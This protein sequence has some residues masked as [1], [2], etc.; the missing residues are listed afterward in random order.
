VL[1]VFGQWSWPPFAEELDQLTVVPELVTGGAGREPLPQRVSVLAVIADDRA[2]V[3]N[4]VGEGHEQHAVVLYLRQMGQVA[5]LALDPRR[6]RVL[7]DRVRAALDD[8]G[9]PLAEA[10]ADPVEH[11]PPAP[12]LDR[13]VKHRRNRL[14]LIAPLLEH[15]ARDDEQMREVGN[16]GALAELTAVNFERQLECRDETGGELW[17]GVSHRSDSPPYSLAS[18]SKAP[19]PRPAACPIPEA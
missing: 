2:G 13:V 10:I 12:V 14:V 4:L 17:R 1:Q 19:P 3:V 16:L 6:L 5:T 7:V 18:G 15:Q 8:R 9:D 11:R